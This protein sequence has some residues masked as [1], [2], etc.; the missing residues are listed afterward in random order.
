MK[1]RARTIK[2]TDEVVITNKLKGR[3]MELG[4]YKQDWAWTCS[5]TT[6]HPGVGF[7]GGMRM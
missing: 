3:M 1:K 7:V 6:V 2:Q 5:H 4:M